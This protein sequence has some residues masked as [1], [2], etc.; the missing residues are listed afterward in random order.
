MSRLLLEDER[1]T[2]RSRDLPVSRKAPW[3]NIPPLS[4]TC[5]EHPYVIKN[6]SRALDS[7]GG[8]SK[9]KEV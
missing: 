1:F 5:I 6:I 8:P 7:L 2:V 9:A 4:I 3:F